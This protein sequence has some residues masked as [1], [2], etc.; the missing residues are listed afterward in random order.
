[1]AGKEGGGVHSVLGEGKSLSSKQMILQDASSKFLTL[2]PACCRA[3]KR[4]YLEYKNFCREPFMILFLIILF[5]KTLL[6]VAVN[7]VC[8]GLGGFFSPANCSFDL[9]FWGF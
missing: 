1:M 9:G 6:L 4:G 3:M 2:W 5:I 7:K 8:D